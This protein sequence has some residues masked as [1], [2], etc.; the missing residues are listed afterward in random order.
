V[1]ALLI[2]VVA[3]PAAYRVVSGD[4]ASVAVSLFAEAWLDTNLSTRRV[5]LDA[6]CTPRLA[7]LLAL[8]DPDEVPRAQ[9]GGAPLLVRLA[10]TGVTYLQRLSSASSIAIDLVRGL[11]G[12]PG[13][14]VIGS[15]PGES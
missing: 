13:W 11:V 1:T 9:P 3:V 5:G 14:V 15:R 6:V 12:G 2:R 4:G 8:S 7:G 10:V